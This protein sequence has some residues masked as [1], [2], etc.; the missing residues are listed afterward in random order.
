MKKILLFICISA[1]A[2]VGYAQSYP[3]TENTVRVMSYNI[4]NGRGMDNRVDYQRLADV[5]SGLAPDVVAL[6]ELD[7]VTNRSGGVD[8]LSRLASLTAMYPVYGASIQY[9]GGKYG[10]AVL[11]KEKPVSWKRIPLP[12][13]EEARSLLMVEFKDYLF[14]CTHFSLNKDDR[15]ASTGIINQAVKDF[16]KPVILAGDLNDTPETPVLEAFKQNWI[17]LSNTKQLTFPSDEPDRTIDYIF[18]YTPKGYTYSVWQTGILKGQ[19]ASDHLPVFADVRLRTAKAGIFRTSA[20]LQN[21]ATDAMTV[22][23]LTNVPCRDLWGGILAKAPFNV[24]LNG[25]TH[26]FDYIPKGKEGNTFPV[27][28]GGGP[29]EKSAT[30]SILRKQGKQMTLTVLN[31]EGKTLLSLS[32]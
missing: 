8:V 32:L 16:N 14:C 18:G 20:Y 11:S 12:G 22:M 30:V 5:I 31:A 1:F 29:S 7:S 2:V 23:W 28:V 26:R 15:L 13:R 27:I 17:T 4:R 21:P 9:D 3:Q 10:I 19:M 25:H 24:S 6:Q